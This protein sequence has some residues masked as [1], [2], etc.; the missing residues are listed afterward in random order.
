MEI[1]D[2]VNYADDNT[3]S[4]IANT[5]KLVLDALKQYTK[6]AMEWFA[7]LRHIMEANP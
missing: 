3:L 6:N 5:V 1:C 4:T 2:F 7:N